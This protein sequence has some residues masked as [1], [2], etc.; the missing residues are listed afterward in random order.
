MTV[1][2]FQIE[3]RAREEQHDVQAQRLAREIF[4][5]PHLELVAPVTTSTS[6]RQSKFKFRTAQ[7]YRLTGNLTPADIDLLTTNL[8]VDPVIQESYHLENFATSSAHIVDVFFL[9]GV[10]DTLAESVID[11]AKM[12]GITQIEQAATGR[13][14]ELDS[15][16]SE[17]QVRTITEALLYNPVIQRYALHRAGKK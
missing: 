4:F 14:Y 5:L 8:L 9:P 11:G 12:L 10:T 17:V 13:R 15:R 2:F 3:V 7:L 6:Q 1:T 16:L